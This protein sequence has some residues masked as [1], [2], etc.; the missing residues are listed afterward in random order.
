MKDNIRR[1]LDIRLPAGQSAF[2][3]GPRKTGKTTFLKEHFSRSIFFD[4][5]DADLYVEMTKKPSLLKERLLTMEVRGPVVLD[6]VQKVPAL[7]DVVHSLIEEKKWSFVLCGSSARKLK[8]GQANLLGGR[9]WRY[10]MFPLVFPEIKDFDL[11][12]ALNHGLLPSHYLQED[13][14]RSLR[15][16]VYDYLKEEVFAEGLTR[17]VPAFSRFFDAMAFD[18]GQIVNFTNISRDCGVDVKTVQ[19]YYQILVD[20]FLGSFLEPYKRHRDRGVITRAPK[21]YLFDVGVAGTLIKRQIKTLAGPE[22]GRALEHFIFME[23][24]AYNRYKEKDFRIRY[25]RTKAG[26]EVDFVLGDG[27]VAIEVKGSQRVGYQ[28][29]HGLS[30]FQEKYKPG[31]SIVVS[32]ERASRI[33]KGILFLPWRD[34]LEKLW[35][36]KII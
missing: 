32:N 25:W 34:F 1:V 33:E 21:F 8:R 3:W 13:A 28:D 12:R 20:T 6:E 10:E 30:A 36:G 19:Q 15:G 22:F 14:S 16:Y 31:K 35:A 4:F 26:Q 27:E 18:Q 17:N 23:I 29:V 11:L 9:A 2:L 24:M 7:L 5:L